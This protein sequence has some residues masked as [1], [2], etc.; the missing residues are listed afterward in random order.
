MSSLVT[1]GEGAPGTIRR[2]AHILSFSLSFSSTHTQSSVTSTV[3]HKTQEKCHAWRWPFSSPSERACSNSTLCLAIFTPAHVLWY[4]I[5]SSQQPW[6]A[7]GSLLPSLCVWK[8]E[9]EIRPVTCL[10]LP[11][12]PKLCHHSTLS[13]GGESTCGAETWKSP[14]VPFCSS[15]CPWAALAQHK[16]LFFSIS[17]E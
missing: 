7:G 8:L 10:R 9:T 3:S 16:V 14:Q 15:W 4:L 1:L 17:V 12:L 5:V 13:S 11:R 2:W 6:K